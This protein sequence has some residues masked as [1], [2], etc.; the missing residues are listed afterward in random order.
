MN[1]KVTKTTH[2]TVFGK[3]KEFP[4]SN[5]TDVIPS[6][7][8]KSQYNSL[9]IQSGSVDISNLNTKENPQTYL[10]YSR[11]ETV[12]SAKNLFSAAVNA[13]TVQ[14]SLEKVVIMK[15]T[16]R[17]DSVESDPLSL[18]PVLAQLFNTT[19]TE[20]WMTCQHKDK[21]FIGT[22]NIE[23]SGSIK[24]SRYRETKT[25]RFD[26]VHLYGSSGQKAYTLSVLNILKAAQLTTSDFDF[27]QSCAQSQYRQ[28]NRSNNVRN[29]RQVAGQTAQS[30]G[31]SGYYS[32]PTQNR[33][34]TFAKT[35]QGN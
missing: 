32:I 6:Q 7:L 33:F 4:A 18:K 11:Q 19:L 10:E 28:T 34:E 5:F 3:S 20:Q 13:F 26:G 16:P 8:K 23:C 2:H 22:H 1:Y 12:I 25:G 31:Q 15:Q 27:H 30:R 9:V 24:E 35:N 29:N 21:I 17:Y 14:P